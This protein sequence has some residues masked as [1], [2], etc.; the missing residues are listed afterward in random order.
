LKPLDAYVAYGYISN[1]SVVEL[2]HRRA[3]ISTPKTGGRT[4]LSDNLMVEKVLGDRGLLC[5]ND[6]SHEI[7]TIGPNFAPAT[8]ILTTFKLSAPVGHFEKK[9]L[10]IHDQVEEKGGFLADK[11]DDFLNKIL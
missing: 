9:I 7:F 10:D 11:M 8:S 4:A 1:K 6:L 5:L 3:Y 2:V